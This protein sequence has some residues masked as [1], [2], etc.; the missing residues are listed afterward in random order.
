MNFL[1]WNVRGI[2]DSDTRIAL[3]NLYLSHN[4]LLT[5]LEDLKVDFFRD[6]CGLPNYKF[7]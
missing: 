2:G 4:P 7:P 3:K 6:N 1:Y 5:L